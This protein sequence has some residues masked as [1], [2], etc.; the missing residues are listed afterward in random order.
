VISRTCKALNPL[1]FECSRISILIYFNDNGYFPENKLFYRLQTDNIG[2]YR[3]NKKNKT[4]RTNKDKPKSARGVNFP[5]VGIGASAGGLSAIEAFFSAMPADDDTGFAFVLVQHLAPDHK[6]ILTELVQRYTRMQVFEVADGMAVQP[7][8]VYII[9]PN[10]DMALING[11]L[12]LLEQDTAQGLRLSIDFFFR[13]LAHDLHERAIGIILS[14]TGSDGTQGVRAIKGEGGMAM[15]Q[16]PESAEYSGMPSSAI[17]TGLV[18][19]ILP[20]AEMPAQ[21]IAYVTHAFGKISHKLIQIPASSEDALKKIFVL[22][23][24][25]TGHDFSHYKLNT[26]IRRIERRMAVHQIGQLDGY[27]RYLKQ[28]AME[29]TALFNDLLIG[30]TRFFRDPHVFKVLEEKVIPRLFADKPVGASIRVWA[31][32]CS[33]GEEAYSIAMLLQERMETKK[34]SFKLQVFATDIDNAAI[35]TARAGVY[36]AGIAA[37]LSPERLTRFFSKEFKDGVFRINKNI[38]DILVFSEQD[39]AK[40]PPFSRLDLISCRNLFIYMSGELQKK[41]MPLFHYSLLPGGFLLLGTSETIG[42]FQNLFTTIDRKVRLFQRK[43]ASFGDGRR[44]A[45][46]NISLPLTRETTASRHA[47]PDS[48]LSLRETAERA[49]LQHYAPVGALVDEHGDILYLHGRSGLYLEPAPGKAGMNIL[50]MAREGLQRDLTT[51]LHRAVTNKEPAF[52]KGVR[53]K[54]N[55]NFTTVNLTVRPVTAEPSTAKAQRLFLVILEETAPVEPAGTDPAAG[56]ETAAIEGATPVEKQVSSLKQELRAKEEYLQITLQE[57]D[58]ANEE[59]KSSN[60]EMQSVNEE[61]QSTN[62]ELETSKEELQSVNEELSTVNNELVQKV[63]DL[64]RANNDMNNL[65]SGTGVGTIFVDTQLRIQRFTPAIIRI[66]SL[67]S[68][69]VG[70]PVG[71]IVSN[72]MD[73]N[74]LVEDVQGVIDTLIPHEV[75]VRTRDE[76]WYLLRIIP[77]RTLENT[78][79]GAV[80]TF[81]DI[82]DMKRAQDVVHRSEQKLKTV[83]N[84]VTEAVYA[85]DPSYTLIL[86][87]RAFESATNLAWGKPILPG[88]TVLA[89]EYPREFITLWKSLYDRALRGES[90]TMESSLSFKDGLHLFENILNPVFTAENKVSEVVVMSRDITVRKHAEIKLQ[91]QAEELTSTNADLTRSN[92]AMVD[93]ELRMVELKEQVNGLCIR[94]GESPVYS[95]KYDEEEQTDSKTTMGMA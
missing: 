60:E 1:F 38:R 80:I 10:R 20:T 74:R 58:T 17:T 16:T 40:D 25:Q 70:R 23:R 27:V 3:M 33:T 65:L 30:V 82:N 91:K 44:Y 54:T 55:G 8:C 37:D 47:H 11:S 79:E 69:D 62:E 84:T 41:L 92:L 14:G 95:C 4:S 64:S 83:L 24:V 35:N 6:S 52:Q 42:E 63:S 76:K 71:H 77:Y 43:E 50:K 46:M 61:M 94:L 22:L 49:M 12:Q 88:E 72:L 29:V 7:N 26:I 93:R 86:S 21:L 31:P 78:I 13:S 66:I 2:S 89:K 81:V 48:G 34:E 75:E 57:L 59:L 53:V 36:P 39:V 90:F 9:P 32:G 56:I 15:V 28:N 87:N 73:Y 67:I 5:V 51:A 45:M 68:T 18:D 85:I 19:Y